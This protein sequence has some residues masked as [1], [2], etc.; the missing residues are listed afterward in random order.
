M[1]A[2]ESASAGTN[3]H[4]ITSSDPEHPANHICTLCRSF[5]N[6]G[7]VGGTGGGTSIKRGPH[8]FIAPSGVQ[9]ELM[10]PHNIFVLEHANRS[11]LRKPLELKPSACTPL[12]LAA[13]DRGAG[14]C[15]H[16]HSQWAVLVTLLVEQEA[17]AKG[18]DPMGK[19]FEIEK[20]EQI[21]GIPKGRGKSGMLGFFDKLVVPIIENTAHEEDLTQ[22]LEEAMEKYPDT[23][24][25]LVRRH[26]V[27]VWG[28]NVQK[29]KTQAESMDYLFRLAVEMKR[30]GLPWVA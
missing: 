22:S 28:D 20:I 25:V 2:T 8:I 12:F 7:W 10:Q 4:L 9:K 23:Y 27:Y 5:Y 19:C 30:L 16:T 3:D 14:C 11:Y 18:E 21:K 6:L 13:F 1:A 29:A 24:A 26:G 17:H 15:I